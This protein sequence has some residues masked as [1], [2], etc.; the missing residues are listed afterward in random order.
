M[1]YI[2]SPL[3]LKRR[4][5]SW[6]EFDSLPRDVRD[7]LNYAAFRY[8]ATPGIKAKQILDHDARCVATAYEQ[9]EALDD[10]KELGL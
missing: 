4:R 1:N 9:R 6:K 8:S 3:K 10:L 2:K 5:F 7:A